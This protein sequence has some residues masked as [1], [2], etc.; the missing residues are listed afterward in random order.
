MT[1]R[2]GQKPSDPEPRRMSR[3]TLCVSCGGV[4]LLLALAAP[5][6]RADEINT[7][8]PDFVESSAVVGRGR[9]QLETSVAGERDNAGGLRLRTLSTPTLLR[10]GVSENIELRVESDGA[11]HT[12]SFD[13]ASGVTTKDHGW[14]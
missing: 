14:A 7:D 5:P 2:P 12:R 13:P 8:R 11:M 3:A 10:L 4:T 6:L 9:F 1:L